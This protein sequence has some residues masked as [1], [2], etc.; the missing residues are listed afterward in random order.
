MVAASAWRQQHPRRDDHS[1]S[2]PYHG[3]IPISAVALLVPLSIFVLNNFFTIIQQQNNNN[4]SIDIDAMRHLQESCINSTITDEESA[5]TTWAAVKSTSIISSAVAVL[6]AILYELLRRDPIVGKYVYDR[7]RL[8]EHDRTPP[9]LMLSRSLWHGNDD[10]DND[11]TQK[12]NCWR[13]K[14]A[15]LE[16]LFINLDHKYVRYSKAA[17]DAR[18]AREE[19]GYYM[20]CR[21][22]WYHNCCFGN[23]RKLLN[24]ENKDDDLFVDEDG[25]EYYPGHDYTLDEDVIANRFKTEW[26]KTINDLFPIDEES[27]NGCSNPNTTAE[28]DEAL[29]NKND[30]IEDLNL[31]DSENL[32]RDDERE[33]E[34]AYPYRMVYLFMPP[35]FHVWG[36]AFAYM[37]YFFCCPAITN[38]FRMLF[39]RSDPNSGDSVRSHDTISL[40]EPEQ[41]LLRCVGLD[42]YLLLR[43]ARLGFDA[44]Y[45]P[46]LVSCVTIL[47]VY[48]AAAPDSTTRFLSL[49]IND[50]ENG[51]RLIWVVVVFSVAFFFYV[52]RRLWIEW[53]IFI[54]LRHNF[55]AHGARHFRDI[56]RKQQK[57][58]KT[59]IV[60]CIPY[61]HRTDVALFNEFNALFPGQIEQAEMLLET[62]KLEELVDKRK[63][64]I[65]R[66]ENIDS[67]YRYKCWKNRDKKPDEPKV[68]DLHYLFIQKDCFISQNDSPRFSFVIRFELVSS[69]LERGR[70]RKYT[71]KKKCLI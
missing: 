43:F 67:L 35:G 32:N 57:Y 39:R 65:K 22:G 37:G 5:T 11:Q 10:N 21:K 53:E 71:T 7:K 14:P 18:K 16:L 31:N 3:M 64:L 1:V 68:R 48:Y 42:I 17:D 41:E 34:I 9:P 45:Y 56:D 29:G 13:V 26:S 54:Q 60:E 59:C 19:N 40:T 25:Y 30:T 2:I 4:D 55:L 28:S 69:V 47:P 33:T 15:I 46:F 49:T 70:M 38:H 23:K 62:S 58:Q 12:M 66:H 27:S 8:K 44:T 51:S 24:N 52:L 20:C 6:C 63:K 36:N 61:S 50:M